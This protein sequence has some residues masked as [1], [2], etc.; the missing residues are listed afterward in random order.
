MTE[1]YP[2]PY[3]L[4][5]LPSDLRYGLIALGVLGLMS[6]ISTFSL[7]CWITY[8]FISW[9]K[10]YRSYVGYNQ[11]I[12]LIYNLL[13]ADLIQAMS[14]VLAFHWYRLQK[15]VA[16]TPACFAQ[17]FLIHL[18]DVASGLFVLSIA[19]HT[20]ITVVRGRKITFNQLLAAIITCWVFAL[21]L[22]VFGPANWGQRFFTRAGAWV[23]HPLSIQ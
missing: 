18:G 2:Y 13:L 20:W 15:I 4:D 16:P 3:S 22:T 19:I 14:F 21:F 5:P 6:A 17:G 7:L 8:R 1:Y 12:V 9:R 10:Y 11:Y 23:T